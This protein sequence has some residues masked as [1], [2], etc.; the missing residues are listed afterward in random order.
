MNEE[1]NNILRERR[2]V[3]PVQFNGE[4]I[5][6]LIIKESKKK[7]SKSLISVETSKTINNI[8]RKVVSS[9]AGT[10]HFADED[11]YYVGGKTGT[12][13]GYGDKKDRINTFI[14]TKLKFD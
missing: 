4:I 12:A 11:G 2:S 3:F 5:D 14:F 1:F 6:D 8:L 9:K 13:E 10:A 7:D